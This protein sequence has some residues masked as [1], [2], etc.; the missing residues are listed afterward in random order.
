MNTFFTKIIDWFKTPVGRRTLLLIVA[1]IVACLFFRQCNLADK[2]QREK[3]Q[4]EQ[5]AS[6]LRDSLIITKNKAGEIEYSR[7]VLAT[8]NKELK[9]QN[10]SLYD[11]AKKQ[12]GTVIYLSKINASLK[13]SIS[14]LA[15]KA[16]TGNINSG[17][18]P[19]GSKYIDFSNDTTYSVG[20]ERHVAGK[21]DF[22]LNNDSIDKKS[23]KVNLTTRQKFTITTG[24]EEDKDTKLLKI[25]ITPGTPNMEISKIDGALI[26]PQKSEL[27]QSYFKPKR[28]TCGPQI[29]IGITNTLTPSFYVGF[30]IQYNLYWKDI[31]NI[32][33]K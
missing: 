2:Y 4:T 29:G 15:G 13:D 32:F 24:L 6:Y 33:K 12:K 3:V 19:D 21:V 17:T 8:T 16:G 7:S 27:I 9:D 10:K 28:F 20:N 30:G 25:F 26:D 18:N 5:N 22:I 14:I 31:K 11:E 1:F 23:I